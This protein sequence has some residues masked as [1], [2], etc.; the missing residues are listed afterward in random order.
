MPQM[1]LQVERRVVIWYENDSPNGWVTG[2]TFSIDKP[3]V[4]MTAAG[5]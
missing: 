1:R 3:C 4:T 2:K 5:M